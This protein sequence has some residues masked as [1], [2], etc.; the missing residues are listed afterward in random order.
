MREIDHKMWTFFNDW[1][2][3]SSWNTAVTVE[4]WT[5]YMLLH[6][7]VIAARQIDSKDLT[8]HLP[9]R[10]QTQTTKNRI[11]GILY[12]MWYPVQIKAIN[13]IWFIVSWDW[14]KW[15]VNNWPNFIHK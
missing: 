6:W 4:D 3:G 11:N 15:A 10:Y 8:L 13:T 2:A 1:V 14:T 5:V 9:V 7:N 12:E